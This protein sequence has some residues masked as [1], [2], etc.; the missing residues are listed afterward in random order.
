VPSEKRARQRAGREA[1]LAA[2]QK[3]VKRKKLLRNTITVII[4]MVVVGGSVYL[5]TRHSSPPTTGDAA[6]QAKANDLAVAAGCPESP[7]TRVNTQSYS[8]PP[9]M[10]INTSQNYLATVKTTAGTFT[11]TLEPSLAPI[12]VN[13]FVFLAD[14]GFYKCVIFHR[15]IPDFMNQTGDPTGTGTGGPGYEFTEAGPAP[16]TP[17]Y[18]IGSVAMANSNNPASTDPSTNGSQFFIVTGQ[19]GE[20]LPPDYT[21]FGK[22]ASGMA[23]VQ[24]INALGNASPSANGVPPKVIHRILSVKVA[25]VTS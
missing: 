11:I 9:A 4:L 14:K 12:S 3:V 24:K 6:L 1:R 7:S 18:P 13:N 2:Q 15:V 20:S 5:I 8:A 10:T 16:A 21:L 17:Q 19:T 23:V 22:V 25:P